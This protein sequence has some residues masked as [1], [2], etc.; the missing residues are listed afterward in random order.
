MESPLVS[1]RDFTLS[2]IA[3]AVLAGAMTG[4][5]AAQTRTSADEPAIRAARDR[6]NKA[7]AVHDLEAAAEIWSA[8]YVGVSSGNARALSREEE[9]RQFTELVATRP[10]VTYLRTPDRISVNLAWQQA[11]ESGHW[12]G[13][14]SA[15]DGETRVGG[16]YFAKWK[17]EGS[18]WRIIAETF[19]QLSCSGTRYCD[20]PPAVLPR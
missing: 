8:D 12:S 11:G 4:R 9:R 18:N 14:W 10:H 2:V 3:V 13:S 6:S 7:I 17:K 5:L 19:V 20:A 15:A 16:I 1:K